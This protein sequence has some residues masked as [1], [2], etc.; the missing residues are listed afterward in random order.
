[1]RVSWS[2][3]KVASC[4]AVA[5]GL[6]FGS[7]AGASA[8]AKLSSG[9]ASTVVYVGGDDLVVKAAD[10][11]LLNYS[12]AAGTKF[13]VG[14]KQEALAEL[15]PGTKLTKEVST[16]FDPKLVTAVQVVKGKVFQATPPD[17]VTLTLSDGIKELTVPG[18]TI[19]SVDG[20]SVSI[21]DLKPGM[22]VQATVVT[23]V[24]D[25]APPETANAAP[26][27]A[28]PMMGAL[29][30]SKTGSDSDLPAAGT[31]LPLLGLIG[32]CLLLA[33]A[34]LLGFRKLAA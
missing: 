11:K 10:G 29:L 32:L 20:K 9:P 17:A 14:D 3:I 7:P 16:G 2:S 21:N 5:L 22:T 13:T 1:M 4:A 18:G 25:S 31:Q 30:V 15:K 27:A 6:A 28:P 19:F 8:Q 23:T 26:P 34:G 24:G 33:G 12:V